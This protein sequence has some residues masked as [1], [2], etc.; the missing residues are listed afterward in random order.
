M[1]KARNWEP[2]IE[3]FH[4]KLSSWKAINLSY[5]GRLTLIKS[6]LGA[7]GG[8]SGVGMRSIER[9]CVCF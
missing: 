6:V 1:N 3:K 4:K 8:G 7:L 2:I 9:F 5:G